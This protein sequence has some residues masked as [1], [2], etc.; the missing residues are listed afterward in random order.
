VHRIGRTG[1]AGVKGIAVSL[2]CPEEHNLLLAIETLL[3]QKIPVEAVKG[4][5]EDSDLPD[6]VLYRPGNLKSER[7]AP[8]EIKAL[9]TKKTSA[10][11]PV[12]GRGKKPKDEKSESATGGKKTGKPGGRAEEGK[13]SRSDSKPRGGNAKKPGT[14]KGE[15]DRPEPRG[16]GRRNERTE[17][18]R[19]GADKRGGNT[20]GKA[21]RPDSRPAQPAR[22]RSRGRG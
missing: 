7:N 15:G 8:R 5:T 21:A 11:L 14:R 22:G 18:S 2:V 12:Q 19:A 9:V 3:R 20:R 13:D 6:F 4:F 16:R 17:D 1:R 10:K